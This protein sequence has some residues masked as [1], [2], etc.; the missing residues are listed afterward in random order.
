MTHA[1][2]WLP[3]LNVLIIPALIMLARVAYQLG[4]L[5]ATV[6]HQGEDIKQVRAEVGRVDSDLGEL[7][8]LVF[9]RK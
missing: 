8:Q 7:R 1:P 6:R 2:D 5:V 4:Q 9:D 3:W